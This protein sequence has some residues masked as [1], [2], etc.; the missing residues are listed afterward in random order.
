LSLAE[1]V[2]A[3]EITSMVAVAVAAQG[4]TE[5]RQDLPSQEVFHTT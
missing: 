1:V 4:D 3:L 5:P 2:A